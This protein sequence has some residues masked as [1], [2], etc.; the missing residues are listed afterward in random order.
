M[1]PKQISS[2]KA[3]GWTFEIEEWESGHNGDPH[4]SHY[5]K[6]PRLKEKTGVFRQYDKKT[7]R[8]LLPWEWMTK[9]QILDR[10][11]KAYANQ[12]M[13]LYS[14]KDAVEKAVQ[15]ALVSDP[16]AKQITVT[17]KLS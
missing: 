13:D 2:L 9:E 6:S 14:N 8:M 17:I 15:A 5:I 16:D 11:K 10:E 7:N 12:R 4:E 3:Q 1:T